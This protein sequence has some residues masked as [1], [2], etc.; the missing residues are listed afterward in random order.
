MRK[1]TK[2]CAKDPI[3]FEKLFDHLRSTAKIGVSKLNKDD[4]D[5]LEK[6]KN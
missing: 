4:R 3:N 5:N 1:N 6:Y 2:L